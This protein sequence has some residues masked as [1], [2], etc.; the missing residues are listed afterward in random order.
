ME[1]GKNNYNVVTASSFITILAITSFANA[2]IRNVPG[3][4]P[5]LASA[6][7]ACNDGDEI[8]IANGTYTG[9]G[10]RNIDIGGKDIVIRSAGGDPTLCTIDC[11]S[12][13]R[14]FT[15]Q[16]GEPDTVLIEGITIQDATVTSLGGAGAYIVNA[17]SPIFTDCRFISCYSDI[18]SGLPGGSVYVAGGS[19]P[20]FINCDFKSGLAA[21]GGGL[22][23]ADSSTV[24]ITD[25]YWDMN[26]AY[27]D[28]GAAYIS[29][30]TVNFSSCEF[31]R[32]ISYYVS[33]AGGRGG[34]AYIYN[35]TVSFDNCNVDDNTAWYAGGSLAAYGS[36]NVTLN[37][38]IINSCLCDING[39]AIAAA[40]TSSV[41]MTGVTLS[42]NE[43]RNNGGGIYCIDSASMEI[44]ASSVVIENTT[45]DYGGGA[46]YNTTG[47]VR[48]SDTSFTGNTTDLDGGGLFAIS[49][50]LSLDSCTFMS[51]YANARGGAVNTELAEITLNECYFSGN[52]SDFA[53]GAAEHLDSTVTYTN[54][55]FVQN[56]SQG[57]GGAMRFGWGTVEIQF[58]NFD[59]NMGEYGG[60]IFNHESSAVINAT[61]FTSNKADDGS[62]SGY[63]GAITNEN[64]SPV[65][66]YCDFTSN[67]AQ[68]SGGAIYNAYGAPEYE[69][70][71]FK[72]NQAGSSS[73][74]GGAIYNSYTSTTLTGCR[75]GGGI[76]NSNQ[77]ENGG[78]IYNSG[79]DLKL[80]WSSFDLNIA[81]YKGGAIYSTRGGDGTQSTVDIENTVFTTNQADYGGG[82]ILLVDGS[83]LSVVNALFARNIS[84]HGNGGAIRDKDPASQ[85]DIINC[86]F[87]DNHAPIL[88]GGGIYADDGALMGIYNSIFRS[89]D[90]STGTNELSQI[91]WLAGTQP[92]VE[93]CNIEGLSTITGTGVFDD[94]ADFVDPPNNN[95]RLNP[96][97]TSLDRSDSTRI[98]THITLDLDAR[99]RYY[100]DPSAPNLG[101][102]PVWADLGPYETRASLMIVG[103]CGS[104]MDFLGSGFDAGEKVVVLHSTKTGTTTIPSGKTCA[105][106]VLGL[107]TPITIAKTITADANGDA[108]FSSP[109]PSGACGRVYVQFLGKTNCR[110]TNV[111][112]IP[113]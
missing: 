81:W 88:N 52:Y 104:V 32:N 106:V 60:A 12:L 90:D 23:I 54:C 7:A 98:P 91:Y 26:I 112:L 107:G 4:Y 25:C 41:T 110:T 92:T 62:G 6:L 46:Y 44:S 9:A 72:S 102:G 65:I 24:D 101:V 43:S 61:D 96:T 1:N 33:G 108:S 13:D 78:A 69:Q 109:V 64:A 113:G 19:S 2:T 28:G 11:Q 22:Y 70:C 51:N 89:N 63:G 66:T 74:G 103:T 85:T 67:T 34:T 111:A 99:D 77:A 68:K 57:N 79:S 50:S 17:S 59:A 100:D 42:A 18:S 82:A 40:D 83:T 86:T 53:A 93:Y 80:S 39:G 20:K 55:D 71:N 8:R 87:F 75:F 73:V 38:M 47:T 37:N 84:L 76:G 94:F 14:A 45:P 15:F 49:S 105:G 48:I 36:S 5:D 21:E 95:F 31:D 27:G 58:C 56:Y 3:T 30:S 16:S 35:S 97:S 29:D 10:F